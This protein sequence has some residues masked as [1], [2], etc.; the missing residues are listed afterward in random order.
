MGATI[1][2]IDAKIEKLREKK[3]SLQKKVTER[4]ARLAIEA[5]L[6][7]VDVSDDELRA[8]FKDLAARFQK[9]PMEPV[10]EA[11]ATDH[12]VGTDQN[13]SEVAHA[14]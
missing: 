9:T 2:N 6:M 8:G 3:R 13:P 14:G 12:G 4:V 11:D 7:D 1:T 5:G 10:G